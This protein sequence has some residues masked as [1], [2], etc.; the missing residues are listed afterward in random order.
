MSIL[1]RRSFRSLTFPIL[2]AGASLVLAGCGFDSPRSTMS[3]AA[4]E[5]AQSYSLFQGLFWLAMVVFVVVEGALL[6]IVYR[7]RRRPG[8]GI[9]VQLHGNQTIELAWTIAP[10][11]IVAIIAIFTFRTQA[12]LSREARDP[13]KVTVIGHQWWWEFQYPDYKFT[14]ANEVHIP[15]GRDVLFSLRSADVI[16]SFHLPRLVDTTDLIPGREN[17]VLVHANSDTRGLIAGQCQEFCGGTHAMMTMHAV[18]EDQATFDTW[19]Q[20]QQTVAGVPAG[21]TQAASKTTTAAESSTSQPPLGVPSA[22]PKQGATT[23]ATVAATANAAP[24]AA[25]AG[26]PEAKGYQLFSAKGCIGCHAIG[27]YPNAVAKIGPNLTHVGGRSHIVSGWLDNTS[28]NMQTWLR[29][30]NAVKPENVMGKAIKRGTL[31]EDDINALT[32]YLES[33]K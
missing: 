3:S 6:F 27:G 20:Q 25:L 11:V 13:I 22:S 7:F 9:P 18:V 4:T 23:A 17:R 28:A 32:A 21:I 26:S 33:L 29:D 16:H 30:P 31:N 2:V 5:S 12:L 24:A 15:A 10:A 14:T 19:I 8:Q 1:S